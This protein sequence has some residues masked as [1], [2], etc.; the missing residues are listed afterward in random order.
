LDEAGF[1]AFREWAGEEPLI[2]EQYDGDQISGWASGAPYRASA[3]IRAEFELP[4]GKLQVYRQS[5][6]A[7]MTDLICSI[8][9]QEHQPAITPQDALA[10]LAVAQ[11]ATTAAQS[12][13]W[14][15]V[16]LRHSNGFQR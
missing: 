11:A 1:A 16:L 15:P 6:R 7:V 12:G 9:N 2:Q 4:E 14:E 10:S 3:R 8:Q 5:I 13:K